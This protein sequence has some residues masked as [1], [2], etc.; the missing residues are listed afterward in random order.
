VKQYQL[1]DG[2]VMLQPDVRE[3]FPDSEAVNS[4]LRSLINLMSLMPDKSKSPAQKAPEA[5]SKGRLGARSHSK[6][7]K[8]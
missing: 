4:A 5:S 8:A 6:A 1:I 3:Y 7:V 2:A